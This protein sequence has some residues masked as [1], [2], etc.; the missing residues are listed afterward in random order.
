M[1]V[2]LTASPVGSYRPRWFKISE[3]QP[4]LGQDCLFVADEPGSLYNRRIFAGRFDGVARFST[5]GFAW[6][7]S[8][9]MPVPDLPEALKPASE[10]VS[11][12][13]HDILGGMT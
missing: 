9:W 12:D 1:R 11:S 3:R 10:A 7:G 2:E 5:P 6:W 13:E 4:F 8:Y